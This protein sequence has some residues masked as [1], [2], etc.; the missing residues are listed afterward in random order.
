MLK[1]KI[2]QELPVQKFQA[3]QEPEYCLTF[4]LFSTFKFYIQHSSFYFHHS[5]FWVKYL[6]K[7]LKI[8][9]RE[10]KPLFYF[11]TRTLLQS[12]QVLNMLK[13]I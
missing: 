2:T 7:D 11:K 9:F 6:I 5:I 13:K 10:H 1:P 12:I 8:N 4:D 3:K